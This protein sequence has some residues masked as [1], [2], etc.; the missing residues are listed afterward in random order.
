[1]A[2]EHH[3]DDRSVALDFYLVREWRGRPRGLEGQA[4]RWVCVDDLKAEELLPADAPVVAAL[5]KVV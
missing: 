1:M 5:K 3:Y 4:L 2:L